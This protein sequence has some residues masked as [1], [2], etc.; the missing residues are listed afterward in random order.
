MDDTRN[1]DTE[2]GIVTQRDTAENMNAETR[3]GQMA[4]R[5]SVGK[6]THSPRS[7]HSKKR[8]KHSKHSHR[9]ALSKRLSRRERLLLGTLHVIPWLLFIALIVFQIDATGKLVIQKRNLNENLTAAQQKNRDLEK[10]K[11]HLDT[12]VANM[13]KGRLPD[14]LHPL[15]FDQ[16][17]Q[18]RDGLTKNVLFTAIRKGKQQKYE[19]RLLVENNRKQPVRPKIKIFIFDRVGIQ[20]GAADITRTP[21]WENLESEGLDAGE[22]RSFSGS[23]DLIIARKPAYFMLGE[24]IDQPRGI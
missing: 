6:K 4:G 9:P 7:A 1:R 12:V 18:L 5:T 22:S 24:S 8:S 20:I 2:N 23:I 13:V 11:D 14:N 15:D 3:S 16:V 19:Y 17:I 21:E 10:E